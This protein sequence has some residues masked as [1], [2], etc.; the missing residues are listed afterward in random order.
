LGKSTIYEALYY[1]VLS[2][3]LSLH[4]FGPKRD[5]VICLIFHDIMFMILVTT[6]K[7]EDIIG[8]RCREIKKYSE[9]NGLK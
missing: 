4:L 2:N 9:G 5:E 1:A 7:N 6:C 8:M 3:L